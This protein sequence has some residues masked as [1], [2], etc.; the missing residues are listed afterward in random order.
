MYK[1]LVKFRDLQDNGHIYHKDDTYPRDG[2]V[3]SPERIKELSGR[4]NA[5]GEPLI[6]EVKQRKKAK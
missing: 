2:V 3:S 6:K 4:K 1:V 5:I